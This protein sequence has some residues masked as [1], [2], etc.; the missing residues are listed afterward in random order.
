M[1]GCPQKNV[2]SCLSKTKYF[3]L[4]KELDIRGSRNA[5][6]ED[7]RA[8]IGIC[9]AYTCPKRLYLASTPLKKRARHFNTGQVMLARYSAYSLN[10]NNRYGLHNYRRPC[11]PLAQTRYS[12]RGQVNQNNQKWEITLHGGATDASSVY[13]RRGVINYRRK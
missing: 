3:C 5:L 8:V 6:P 4:P 2:E 1:K 11:T 12:G 9:T 7:F 13:G 10:F